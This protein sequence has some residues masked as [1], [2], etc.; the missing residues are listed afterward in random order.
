[1]S[2]K[3]DYYSIGLM[4]GSSLDGLDICYSLISVINNEY[5]FDIIHC[6]T[7][8]YSQKII[9]SIRNVRSKSYFDIL[10]L[11]HLLGDLFGK[12]S[13]DFIEKY[14]INNLDFIASH[15]HTI[16]HYPDNF[17]TVQ[18]GNPT[19]IFKY[20]SI[21]TLAHLREND[22]KFG[23]TG[24]P[25]VPIAD[26]YLFNKYTYCL[27][28]GGI[29]NISVKKYDSIFS[30]DIGICNQIL[31]S[32]AQILGQ[33]MDYEGKLAREGD[34]HL[35]LFTALNNHPYFSLPFPKSLDNSFSSDLM[36]IINRFNSINTID[37]I[38]TFT[39]HI[40]YQIKCAIKRPDTILSTGGGSFNTFLVEL[41]H[42]KYNLDI[43]IPSRQLVS[44]K[45]ALAMSLMGVRYFE[46]KYNVLAS[47]TG[48]SKNTINGVLYHN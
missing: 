45:E 3:H 8:E 6:D 16:L 33:E 13:K 19:N 4:S 43:F 37:L 39:E 23:G 15:G 46:K 32:L 2:I 10:S 35:D 27:N 30:Y 28:L 9:E 40:A 44:Y 21:P 20:T 17:I 12:L 31:N 41:L 22:V 36:S 26:K 25:I 11:D 14:H 38:R 47:V 1:M 48:A 18:I 7:I 24:A 42:T 34:I 5:S 29:M